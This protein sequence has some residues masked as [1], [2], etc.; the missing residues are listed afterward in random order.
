MSFSVCVKTFVIINDGVTEIQVVNEQ[1]ATLDL[2]VT[3]FDT[4]HGYINFVKTD[5]KH[6][7]PYDRGALSDQQRH[8][9]AQDR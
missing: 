8:K 1:H 6:Y 9:D 3:N 5:D 7:L 2:Y 4:T